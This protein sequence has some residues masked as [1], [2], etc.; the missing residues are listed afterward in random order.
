[1]ET[2][3]TIVK[4]LADGNRMRI[5]AALMEHDELCVCQLI[6]MLGL[7]GATV[8]RHMSILQAA[9][10][11]K[12]RKQ[13]RWVFYRLTGEF[14]E[15]LRAWLRESLANS[16]EVLADRDNLRTILVCDPEELCRRQREGGE[17]TA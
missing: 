2:S 7:A 13:G 16:P 17:C 10:L 4:G 3:L 15:L 12:N 11:V 8:S 6:E 9:R 1:M 5:V 14:P